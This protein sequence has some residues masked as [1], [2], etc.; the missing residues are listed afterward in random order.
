[1][2]VLDECIDY[3]Q[4]RPG[5]IFMRKHKSARWALEQSDTPRAT[6]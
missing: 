4:K 1:V 2:K 5:V 6:A 3:A